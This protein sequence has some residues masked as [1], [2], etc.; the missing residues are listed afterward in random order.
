[1]SDHDLVS[2]IIIK[3]E[4]DAAFCFFYHKHMKLF[5]FLSNNYPKLRYSA[6][7]LASEMY[8][9]ISNDNWKKLRTFEFRSSL[10][11]WMKVVTNRYLINKVEN[12]KDAIFL[13]CLIE[14]GDDDDDDDDLFNKIPDPNQRIKEEMLDDA[15]L[16]EELYK[17]IDLLSPYIRKVVRL[18]GLV[19]LSAKETAEILCK[20]GMKV[21]PGAVN[22]VYKRAKDI[23][24]NMLLGEG[25]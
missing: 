5:K 14:Y 3:K 22:Q 2:A 23:L 17:K 15:E 1:M 6:D 11:G 25:E 20:S 18:R 10:F 8:I 9:Y 21:T 16:I 24:R 13:A 12:M 7:D 4:E 19:G